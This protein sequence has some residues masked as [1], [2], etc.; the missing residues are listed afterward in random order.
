MRSTLA[1][2]GERPSVTARHRT[3]TASGADAAPRG[4][5][6]TAVDATTAHSVCAASAEPIEMA[7]TMGGEYPYRRIELAERRFR[8]GDLVRA[9]RM[10]G[11]RV[12][13]QLSAPIAVLS[14]STGVGIRISTR[15]FGALARRTVGKRSGSVTPR[16][17]CLLAILIFGSG[18]LVRMLVCPNTNPRHASCRPWRGHPSDGPCERRA[19]GAG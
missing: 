16:H 7:I 18:F 19:R 9:E 15:I 4:A 2:L 1:G 10:F 5:L 3:L 14:L 12:L 6:N 13:D 17:G 8:S 11:S